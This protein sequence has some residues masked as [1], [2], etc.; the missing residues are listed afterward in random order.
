MRVLCPHCGGKAVITS[1][2]SHTA[3]AA[4]LY[5]QCRNVAV[6]G[7]SFVYALG[8]KHT[9]APPK[10]ITAELAAAVIRGLPE[11][12]RAKLAAELSK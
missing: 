7:A 1:R 5:C 9:L 11:A 3:T 8:Y 12:E 2:L 10:E 6:C 4:D